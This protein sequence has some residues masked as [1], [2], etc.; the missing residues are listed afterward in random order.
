MA[1]RGNETA[2]YVVAV[3]LMMGIAIGSFF[4]MQAWD[5]KNPSPY[6]HSDSYSFEGTFGGVDCYGEG[7][8]RYYSESSYDYLYI[9]KYTIHHSGIDS[10]YDFKMDFDR[11]EKMQPS[12]TYID[13]GKGT[14]D[15]T[16][17][18]IWKAVLDGT[19]YT[20]YVG[21][22]CTLIG[23]HIVSDHLDVIGKIVK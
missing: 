13:M 9:V 2:I 18:H 17:V 23:V 19:E 10:D 15:D 5:S 14:F 11:D 1:S 4:M 20:Y 3:L 21:E 8:S 6:D 16:P 22:Y 7:E 12:N